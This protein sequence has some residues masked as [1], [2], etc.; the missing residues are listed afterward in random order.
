MTTMDQYVVKPKITVTKYNMVVCPM[1]GHI[2][3]LVEKRSVFTQLF[4]L[5]LIEILFAGKWTPFHWP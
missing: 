3:F 5:P 2:Y 1:H 4:K